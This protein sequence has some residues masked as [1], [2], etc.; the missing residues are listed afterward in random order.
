[1]TGNRLDKF[2]IDQQKALKVLYDANLV[3][4]FLMIMYVTIDVLGHVT[5]LGFEGFFNKYMASNLPQIK[6]HDLWAARCALLHT[7]S[8]QSKHVKKGK[9][10]SLSY[11]WGSAE[12]SLLNQ[13]IKN[14][15]KTGQVVGIKIEDVHK[16]FV[17]G[18]Q[19]LQADLKNNDKFSQ[20][21][22]PRI[23]EFY[24]EVSNKK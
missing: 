22:L 10:R 17:A 19:K 6:S 14:A 20:Y 21:C 5:G 9:A 24:C 11:A 18:T 15:G 8:S 23:N 13:V 7:N 16:V 1:M 2:I 12:L 4:A 3:G